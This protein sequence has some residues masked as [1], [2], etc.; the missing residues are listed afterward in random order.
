MGLGWRNLP[1]ATRVESGPIKREAGPR[2]QP[3]FRISLQDHD[4]CGAVTTAFLHDV[5]LH[6]LPLAQGAVF[7]R[8][9]ERGE[10]NEHV[11]P[12]LLLNEAVTLRIVEPLDHTG[13]LLSFLPA[14]Q[15]RL[16]RQSEGYPADN[17]WT[18]LW[19]HTKCASIGAHG[20]IPQSAG[21]R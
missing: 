11:L 7:A 6:A 12:R 14:S 20:N 1:R 9:G 5:E 8:R 18:K 17:G 10:V 16:E 15:R 21:N 19:S 13:H 3:P 4:I 2:D